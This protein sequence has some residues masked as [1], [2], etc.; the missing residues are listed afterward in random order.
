[1]KL[2]LK[3][4]VSYFAEKKILSSAIVSSGV[5]L[6][7]LRATNYPSRLRKVT[8]LFPT[9]PQFS[10][11]SVGKDAEHDRS[12][13]AAASSPAG[14]EKVREGPPGDWH[15]RCAGVCKGMNSGE[16]DSSGP[17]GVLSLG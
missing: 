6:V 10:G 4:G 5:D 3:S 7:L 11:V 13:Q 16:H 9:N 14:G 8:S 2:G 12:V 15:R 17:T 1:M